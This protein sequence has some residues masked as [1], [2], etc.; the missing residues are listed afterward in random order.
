MPQ[1]VVSQFVK[2]PRAEVYRACLD[3]ARIVRW[4]V[5]D[6]MTAEIHAFDARAGGRYRMTL[7]YRNSARPAGKTTGD[8]DSFTG[9]FAELIPNEKIVEAISFETDDPDIRGE[10]RIITSFRD[11]DGGTDVTMRFEN[12]PSGIR[13]EDNELGTR[14]SLRKL[15]ALFGNAQ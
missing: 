4:R 7:T 5:P 3:P 11:A 14:Q 9:R 6:N 2:A 12:I 15:A 10:M 8:A 13:P 1:T